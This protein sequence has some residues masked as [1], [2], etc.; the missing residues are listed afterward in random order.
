MIA[1]TGFLLLAGCV[2]TN[3]L[4]REGKID[5]AEFK[6]GFVIPDQNTAS[7][8]YQGRSY[9]RGNWFQTLSI[10]GTGK[11]K[12]ILM[13]VANLNGLAHMNAFRPFSEFLPILDPNLRNLT[14]TFGATHSIAGKSGVATGQQF[15]A[16]EEECIA[17]RVPLRLHPNTAYKGVGDGVIS[18][19]YCLPAGE[20]L[21][22]AG[23]LKFLSSIH[24]KGETL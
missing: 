5:A 9:S 10:S 4:V 16:L 18:G 8:Q 3:S 13:E 7:M 6:G 11:T 20:V 17:F 21:N 12:R 2:A 22:E 14:L 23:A 15:R 1:M 19:Y 24:Y